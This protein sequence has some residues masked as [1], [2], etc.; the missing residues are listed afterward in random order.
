MLPNFVTQEV[1]DLPFGS[2]HKLNDQLAEIFVAESMVMDKANVKK[3]HEA[4]AYQFNAP[5][6]LLVNKTNAYSYTFDA[7]QTITAVP[8]LK[9]IAVLVYSKKSWLV[10]ETLQ[11]L[12]YNKRANMKKFTVREE[13]L[14][15][16]C[17]EMECSS[18]VWN[19][20]EG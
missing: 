12:P 13:A 7:Q 17:N 4:F 19:I 14:K 1:L 16:L 15:W 2:I 18:E 20:K 6:G 5:F 9:A 3:L 11:R 8:H 10:T